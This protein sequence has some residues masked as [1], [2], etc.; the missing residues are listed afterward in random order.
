MW[1][2]LEFQVEQSVCGVHRNFDSAADF[3]RRAFVIE[4]GA[5]LCGIIVTN[6][7]VSTVARC[8]EPRERLNARQ[9]VPAVVEPPAAHLATTVL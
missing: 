7:I 1:F 8:A 4:T 9:E 3:T 2:A 6:L 5:G